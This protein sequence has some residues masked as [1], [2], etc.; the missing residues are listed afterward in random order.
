M[1]KRLFTP[2]T[3]PVLGLRECR[4]AR[5][6][7]EKYFLPTASKPLAYAQRPRSSNFGAVFAVPTEKALPTI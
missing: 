4:T 2:F 1:W 5:L 3:A 7:Q 6:S